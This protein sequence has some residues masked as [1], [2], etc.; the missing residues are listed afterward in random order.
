M[1]AELVTVEGL[2]ELSNALRQ[3]SVR[4]QANGVA[5]AIYAAAAIIR[6]QA[7]ANAPVQT[8]TLKRA[9]YASKDRSKTTTTTKA[10][11]VGVRK[12]KKLR[13]VNSRGRNTSRD[14]YYADWVEFGT[15]KTPAQPFL[16]PAFESTKEEALGALKTR[17]SKAVDDARRA[18]L[19]G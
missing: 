10:M 3:M 4:L 6:N 8:G 9:I 5:A 16:R 14:A 2:S 13:T 7:K 12:G 15:K 18:G 17:L 11:I 1:M 19:G